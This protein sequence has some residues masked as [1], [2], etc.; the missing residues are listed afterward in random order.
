[1]PKKSTHLGS[2]V[3]RKHSDGGAEPPSNPA[4]PPGTPVDSQ[5][6]SPI[7]RIGPA[8]VRLGTAREVAKALLVEPKQPGTLRLAQALGTP[9][10]P[11]P[12][13]PAS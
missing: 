2:R 12:H 9:D 3:P 6:G 1:M 8:A 5:P 7:A 13:V 10:E 11:M 4:R